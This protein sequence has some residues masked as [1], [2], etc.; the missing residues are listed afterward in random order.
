MTKYYNTAISIQYAILPNLT[1]QE[2]TSADAM[3]VKN[4]RTDLELV[5]DDLHGTEYFRLSGHWYVLLVVEQDGIEQRWYK[6]V[7][8]L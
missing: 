8:H 7:Q 1:L 5:D 3:Y 2:V 4:L 6:V